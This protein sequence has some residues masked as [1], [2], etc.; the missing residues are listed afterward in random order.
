MTASTLNA[1]VRP[2]TR[3]RH[4]YEAD[5]VRVLT[6]AC[7]I[8]VHTISHTTSATDVPSNGVEMLLHFTR[9]AFFCLTGFVLLHQS[10]GRPIAL[11]SFWTKRLVAVGVPYVTWTVIYTGIQSTAGFGSWAHEIHHLAENLLFGTAWYHLYFLLVS[12]QIYLL[13]PLIS[14]LIRHTAGHHTA[15]LMASGAAQ[16]AILTV[17]MYFPPRTGW[18]GQFTIHQD[19]LILSYQFYAL[20]GAV[21]AFHLDR[22]RELVRAHR[23]AIAASVVILAVATEAWYLGA[24][25]NG[26]IAVDAAAVLQPVMLPWSIAAVAGLFLLGARYSRRR[27]AGSRLDKALSLGS[28]RSFGVFLV[29]PAVLWLLLQGQTRWLPGLHGISLTATA[30]VLVVAGSIGLTEIF[31]R[32]PLS[33]AL[34]GRHRLRTSRHD[35]AAH[36]EEINH[37]PDHADAPRAPIQA[38]YEGHHDGDRQRAADPLLHRRRVELQ[39][40]DRRDEARLGN[41]I[42]DR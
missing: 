39:R 35:T 6:F 4:V 34:T 23:R 17:Q 2:A 27:R 8:A 20:L 40:A 14:A 41:L 3:Q 12:M 31:R 22:L 9:E 37:V 24:E 21:A 38:A 5:V 36:G 30:Y 15:L 1:S 18:L 10:L 33:L 13:F 11:R 16:L 19:A 25:H 28:D 26:R 42:G 29:H 7:V 32:S